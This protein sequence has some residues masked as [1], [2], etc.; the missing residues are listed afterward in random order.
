V[1]PILLARLETTDARPVTIM[2][3]VGGAQP[4]RQELTIK[5]T[6]ASRRITD[7]YVD[8][9]SDGGPFVELEKGPG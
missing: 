5:G 8:A 1:K 6:S 2:A 9:L 7:F 4:D 3:S